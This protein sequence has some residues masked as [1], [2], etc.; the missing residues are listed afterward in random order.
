M[1]KGSFTV[2][3]SI[4]LGIFILL[5]GIWI[6]TDSQTLTVFTR[7]YGGFLDRNSIVFVSFI[8]FMLLPIVFIGFLHNIAP[9]SPR[10]LVLEIRHRRILQ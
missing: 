10:H 4:N 6:L 3:T 5:S 1:R 8:C 2:Y 7:E 9:T